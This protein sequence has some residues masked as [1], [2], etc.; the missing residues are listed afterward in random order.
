MKYEE[1]EKQIGL[2]LK[3]VEKITKERAEKENILREQIDKK[4]RS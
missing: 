2:R 3:E 4:Y 1:I